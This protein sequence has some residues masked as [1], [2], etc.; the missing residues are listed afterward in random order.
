VI[1][2]HTILRIKDIRIIYKLF[3]TVY[4]SI[5]SEELK[6]FV[7]SFIPNSSDFTKYAKI[8]FNF[9]LK[10][11][12][13][14]C[15]PTK[16]KKFSSEL[17]LFY[18]KMRKSSIQLTILANEY[19]TK[20]KAFSKKSSWAKTLCLIKCIPEPISEVEYNSTIIHSSDYYI[21]VERSEDDTMRVV[22]IAGSKRVNPLLENSFQKL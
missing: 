14:L 18:A 12:K 5:E 17:Y 21:D 10:S 2:R 4:E 20:R 16:T 22:S 7:S 1:L 13:P 6:S 11:L 15:V 8:D 19:E 3:Q 9:F